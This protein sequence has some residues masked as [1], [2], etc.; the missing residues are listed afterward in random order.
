[1]HRI[2]AIIFIKI[3]SALQIINFCQEHGWEGLIFLKD[4]TLKISPLQNDH[5]FSSLTDDLCVKEKINISFGKSHLIKKSSQLFDASFHNSD[6]FKLKRRHVRNTPKKLTIEL[7]VFLDEAAY[8]IFMPILDNDEKML[9]MLVLAY[10]NNVQAM[11]HHPSLGVSIDISLVHLNIMREQPSDLPVFG[12]DD[13]KLRKSFCKYAN[14]RNPPDDNDPSHWDVGLYLTGINIYWGEKSK[15]G[16]L[17]LSRHNSSCSLNES[18]SI[19]EFGNE[20]STSVSSGFAS[21]RTTAHEI[22]HVLGMKHDSDYRKPC[23]RNKYIM[24]SIRRREGQILWSE[25]SRH[26]V[27]ELWNIK[28]CLRDHAKIPIDSYDHSRY[29]NL[30]GRQ[31]TAKAQCEIFLHDKDANVVT[32]L[33]ICKCLQ[34]KTPHKDIFYFTGPALEGTQCAPGKECRG[35]EC[36]PI[37]APPYILEYCEDDNWIE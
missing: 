3:I 21:S 12:G 10:V 7:A 23:D 29:H 5:A 22:G 24:S 35:G 15:S 8:R 11:Y 16:S 4:G 33:N 20:N 2:L 25:C 34:C 1:M 14:I 13:S 31:W 6:N 9:N 28:P 36:V 19:V 37:I 30:P 18:C 26:I 32:L 27:E 17:G